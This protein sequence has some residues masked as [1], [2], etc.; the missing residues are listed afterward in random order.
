M[1]ALDRLDYNVQVRA[2]ERGKTAEQHEQAAFY[3]REN[4]VLKHERANLT[5]TIEK[6]EHEYTDLQKTTGTIYK[7][8]NDSIKR[9]N[10]IIGD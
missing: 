3:A 10:N 7:K 4:E 5:A 9:L 8:L 6:L 1:A 2:A